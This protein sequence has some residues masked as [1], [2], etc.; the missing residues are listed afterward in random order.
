MGTPT[1]SPFGRVSSSCRVLGET[2]VQRLG[3]RVGLPLLQVLLY[4]LI[5]LLVHHL[6]ALRP[7]VPC[8]HSVTTLLHL[9]F[10]ILCISFI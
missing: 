10:Q 3:S 2:L 8:S 9:M 6:I 5:G 7:V 1:V 4:P